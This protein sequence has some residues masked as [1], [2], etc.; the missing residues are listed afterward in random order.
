MNNPKGPRASRW[1]VCLNPAKIF[2][3]TK[4]QQGLGPAFLVGRRFQEQESTEGRGYLLE[5]SRGR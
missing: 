1:S 4:W 3:R 5:W 2:I